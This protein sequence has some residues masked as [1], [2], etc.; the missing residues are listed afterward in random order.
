MSD[1]QELV[2]K[3]TVGG[4]CNFQAAA[5]ELVKEK[6]AELRQQQASIVSLAHDLGKSHRI[7]QEQQGEIERYQNL[8]RIQTTQ[9]AEHIKALNERFEDRREVYMKE[10]ERQ[11]QNI[12]RLGRESSSDHNRWATERINLLTE[13]ERLCE[14]EA[15]AEII[16]ETN[17]QQRAEIERLQYEIKRLK[18]EIE[19]LTA[20]QITI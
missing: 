6:N 14:K 16:F 20:V 3:H 15:T 9:T 7:I 8:F 1:W 11:E 4:A 12:E 13:I 17:K 19:D 18:A 2:I 5:D 10:I